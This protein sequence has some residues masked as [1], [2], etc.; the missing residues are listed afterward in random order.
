M[1]AESNPQ[2]AIRVEGPWRSGR[3]FDDRG[4]RAPYLR[5]GDPFRQRVAQRQLR[6]QVKRA[7]AI[8]DRAS[9]G[10]K[11]AVRGDEALLDRR[12]ASRARRDARRPLPPP[13][14]FLPPLSW[15]F[16]R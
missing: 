11:A 13:R 1:A 8:R 3:A 14:R 12:V 10:R 2:P 9:D 16:V 15:G 6:E 4:Q 5:G 7:E